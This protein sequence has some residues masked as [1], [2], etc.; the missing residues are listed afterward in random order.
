[1]DSAELASGAGAVA[2]PGGGRGQAASAFTPARP[3]SPN[4]HFFL[5]IP[6]APEGREWQMP[7]LFPFGKEG[8]EDVSSEHIQGLRVTG[9]CQPGLLLFLQTALSVGP[10]GRSDGCVGAW[11]HSRGSDLGRAGVSRGGGEHTH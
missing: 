7:F 11:S 8:T 6:E 4:P 2:G 3:A 10:E 5:P 1:M 9:F